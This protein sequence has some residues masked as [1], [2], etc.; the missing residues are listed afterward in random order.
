MVDAN[1]HAGSGAARTDIG[2][3]ADHSYRAWGASKS[4]LRPT[5][6]H[7]EDS[8]W[9]ITTEHH[10]SAFRA[11]TTDARRRR[12]GVEMRRYFEL[13]RDLVSTTLRLAHQAVGCLDGIRVIDPRVGDSE[14]IHAQ[15][16]R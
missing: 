8:C 3:E 16:P 12:S 9:L 4:V 14:R 7:P 5:T 10:Q 11:R 2:G 13:G 1:D 15:G 6:P